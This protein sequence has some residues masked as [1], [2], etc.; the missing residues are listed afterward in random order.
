MVSLGR[1]GLLC[2]QSGLSRSRTTAA[3]TLGFSIGAISGICDSSVVR[4]TASCRTTFCMAASSE[5]SKME[6]SLETGY[7]DARRAYDL[8]QHLFNNGYTLEQLMELAGL[9]VAEAVY[10]CVEG[11]KK[12]ILVRSTMS[13]V[14][15]SQL[16]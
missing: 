1:L 6:E 9:A 13:F 14:P 10:E 2:F 4:S 8:D 7:L 5:S 11:P 3:K 12:N 15:Y 16:R